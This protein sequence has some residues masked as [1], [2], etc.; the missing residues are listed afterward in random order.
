LKSGCLDTL[1]SVAT[2]AAVERWD[3]VLIAVERTRE[4]WLIPEAMTPEVR[5][6]QYKRDLPMI[7]E[8]VFSQFVHAWNTDRPDAGSDLYQVL[9]PIA[10]AIA[11]PL[12][13]GRA[14]LP[15][16][17]PMMAAIEEARSELKQ[18]GGPATAAEVVA[19]IEHLLKVTVLVARVSHQGSTKIVDDE[20]QARFDAINKN[21]P[22]SA[23]YFDLHSFQA[24]EQPSKTTISLQ[25]VLSMIDPGI[26]TLE[27]RMKPFPD[28]TYPPIMKQFAAQWVVNF[29]TEWDEH[30]RHQLALAL[31]CESSEVRSDYFGDLGKMRHDY[32]HNRGICRSSAKNKVLDWYCKGDLMIPK[33]ANYRQLME[34]FPAEEL[35]TLKPSPVTVQRQ[36]VKANADP[37]LTRQ[38]LVRAENLGITKDA[39]LDQ[40]LTDWLVANRPSG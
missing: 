36:P 7:I 18:I 17:D 23:K 15:Q 1:S 8:T 30:F 40:A 20:L 11:A 6:H 21:T 4:S 38:F 31:G 34:A 25:V 29:Y 35:R 2:K 33:H 16:V 32:V 13:F 37:D 19:D 39:A 27:E 24:V 3:K 12:D 22:R 26:A 10:D 9:E 5:K 14:A 28:E